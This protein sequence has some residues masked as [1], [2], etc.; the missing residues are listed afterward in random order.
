MK[1]ITEFDDSIEAQIVSNSLREKGVMTVVT[2]A[3]SQQLGRA[4]T[5]AIDVGLWVKFNNSNEGFLTTLIT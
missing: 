3:D 2:S 5:G 1:L 4:K